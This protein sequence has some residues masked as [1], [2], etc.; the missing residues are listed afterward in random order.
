MKRIMLLTSVIFYSSFAGTSSG[1]AGSACGGISRSWTMERDLVLEAGAP[2][3]FD[4]VAV[5]DPTIVFHDGLYHVFYTSKYTEETAARFRESGRHVPPMRAGTGYVAAPSLQEL[6]DASRYDLSELVDEVV[7][8]PQIFYFEPHATWYM[9]AHRV[10][11]GTRELVPI[12]LTNKNISDIH[13]WSKPQDLRRTRPGDNPFWIDFWVI[14]DDTDAHLFYMDQTGAVLRMECPIDQFPEGLAEA[15]EQVAVFAKGEDD[16]A[17]WSLFEAAHV[18]R[19]EK[20]GDYFMLAECA[21]WDEDKNRYF[22]ARF[23]FMIGFT[24]DSLRG[25]WTRVEGDPLKYFA[26][27]A[28]LRFPDGHATPYTQV[29]HPELIRSDH[30]QRLEISSFNMDML[31]QTFDGSRVPENY[32]YDDLPWVLAI[33]RNYE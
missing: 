26:H 18:Y 1:R 23:R 33:M 3:Q 2:G 11:P 17:P 5:K 32:R 9:I 20:T 31:F 14:C 24:A 4:D 25:P 7:I 8:A 28:N 27:A 16:F 13:G 15:E 12:Y 22:D 21:Y 6:R 29:S 10:V 30:H 19:V